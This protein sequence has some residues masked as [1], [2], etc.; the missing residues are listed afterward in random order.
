MTPDILN[1]AFECVGAMF[2]AADCIKLY[3]DRQ[4]R[5]VYWPGRVFWALWGVWNVTYYPS[6]G[7]VWSFR[8]GL[9]VLAMNALWLMLAWRYRR[10]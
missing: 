6:I 7:Q 5:G 4:L 3:F 9:A 2:I 1:A 10:A 8:A